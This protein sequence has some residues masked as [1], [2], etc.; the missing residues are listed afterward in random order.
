MTQKEI[1]QRIKD[2]ELELSILRSDKA[3]SDLELK[4]ILSDNNASASPE[5]LQTTTKPADEKLKISEQKLN[6]SQENLHKI[7]ATTSEG[8][9]LMNEKGCFIDVN[10]AFIELIGYTKEELL[11]MSI[12]DLEVIESKLETEQHI[13]N[14][15]KIGTE[16][17]DTVMRC[18]NGSLTN[19]EINVSRFGTT[20][21]YFF[22]FVHDISERKRVEEEIVRQ[23]NALSKLNHFAIELSNLSYEDNLEELIAKKIKEISGAEL[24]TFSEF[25]SV[26]HIISVKCIE[27]E[28]GLLKKAVKLLGEKVQNIQSPISDETYDEMAHDLVGFRKTL[29]E[30]SFGAIP[31]PVGASVQALLNV[32]HFIGLA[33]MTDGNLYGTSVL[34]MKKNQTDPPIKILENFVHLA[35]TSLQRKKIEKQLKIKIEELINTNKK[36]EQYAHANEELEQFAFIASHN[37]QQ[38]LRTV[39][40]YIQIFEEDYSDRFDDKAYVYLKTVKDSVS[41]MIQLLNSLLDFSRIGHN[42]DLKKVSCK[43]LIDNAIADL[44]TLIVS[45]DTTIVISS[46]PEL[47]VYESEFSQLIQNLIIN[48]IKFQKPGNKPNIAIRSKRINSGWQFS[49]S[50]NGIG[51]APKYFEK[52]FDIFQRLHNDSDFQGSGIGLSF[53]KKIVQL[54][55]GTIWI[56]SAENQGS[57]VYFTIPDLY[58]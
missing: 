35:A 57:T 39:S 11:T 46:M 53:C 44:E 41:R 19:V 2:I 6:E 10:P 55:K 8:Y 28:P 26:K 7:L 1:E 49:V 58:E 54:H 5:T 21:N 56:E 42:I 50:D 29:H 33:Y 15:A 51:I 4:D 24:S 25:D 18:K 14:I 52:I 47:L 3:M 27:L 22:V 30:I 32:D 20:G 9:W 34:G 16:R 43:Q 48:A 38:P 12:P 13:Q 31:R 36:L 40:N 37:L 23:N 45:T 17:F